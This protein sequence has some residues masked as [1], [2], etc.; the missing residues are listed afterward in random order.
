MVKIEVERWIG[1]K[2]NREGETEREKQSDE[3]EVLE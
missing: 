1:N 3:Q 2:S